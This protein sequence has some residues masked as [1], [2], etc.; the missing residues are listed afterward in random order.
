MSSPRKLFLKVMFS[1]PFSDKVAV[2]LS[3]GRSVTENYM[4]D[5][6]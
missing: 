5:K 4:F 1:I 3:L 6:K 2:F